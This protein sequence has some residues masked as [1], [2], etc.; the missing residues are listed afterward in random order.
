[1][2]QAGKRPTGAATKSRHSTSFAK[3]AR[4]NGATHQHDV[5]ISST[6]QKNLHASLRENTVKKIKHTGYNFANSIIKTMFHGHE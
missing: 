4:T 6:T 2:F 3:K 5:K 1:M